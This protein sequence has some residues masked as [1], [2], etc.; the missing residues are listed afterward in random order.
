[1]GFAP[2]G[3][4]LSC[5]ENFHW[6]FQKTLNDRTLLELRYG[7]SPSSSGLRWHTTHPRFNADLEPNEPNRF[8]WV[9]EIDPF[10]PKSTPVKRTALGRFKHE[11]AWVQEA[12]DGRLVIYMGDDERNEYI[13]RY[14][15]NLPWR[16]ARR[17][18]INPLDDGVLYVAKFH[19]SGFGEWLT[20]TPA[21]AAL[22]AWSL[23]DILINTPRPG[24]RSRCHNDGS[25]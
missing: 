19:D 13:Y 11:G 12:N 2:W 7:I 20:L 25:P 15:S 21:N 17:Q 10:D 8:G 23:N 16:R 18:G 3:T 4:F 1:M 9:V 6:F 14:V 5:E 22:A 24:R